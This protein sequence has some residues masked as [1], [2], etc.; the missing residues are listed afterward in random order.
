MKI[1]YTYYVLMSL[2]HYW[3]IQA[4]MFPW[5]VL[6]KALTVLR[7]GLILFRSFPTTV[8]CDNENFQITSKNFFW[9]KKAGSSSWIN[10]CSPGWILQ[11]VVIDLVEIFIIYWQFINNLNQ[12]ESSITLW[13][14]VESLRI[15]FLN[16]SFKIS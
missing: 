4:S 9:K 14:A 15:D 13:T 3:N 11:M 1:V 8:P 6:W 16:T 5:S 10:T 7:L 2:L 12:Q